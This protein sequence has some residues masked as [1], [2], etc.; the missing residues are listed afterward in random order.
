M[1]NSYAYNPKVEHPRMS[2]NI[3]QMRSEGFQTPFF[4]GGSNIPSDLFLARSSY[5]GARG[6]G[7]FHHGMP[8][9]THQGDLDF[10]TKR[11]DTVFHRKGHNVKIPHTMPFMN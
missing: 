8:S 4:F 5:N 6:S 7:I 11:G 3:P 10:T 2:N 1:S 9:Q